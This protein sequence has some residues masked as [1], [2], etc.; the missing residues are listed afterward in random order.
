MA[1]VVAI[2]H[3]TLDGVMQAPEYDVRSRLI[4]FVQTSRWQPAQMGSR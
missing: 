4:L 3:V 1:K 2:E